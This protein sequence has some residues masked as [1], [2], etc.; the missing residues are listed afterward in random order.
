MTREAVIGKAVKPQVVF[1]ETLKSSS[2]FVEA[3]ANE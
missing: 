2:F 1:A 3:R